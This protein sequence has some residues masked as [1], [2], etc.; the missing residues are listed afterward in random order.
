[1]SEDES[2][3]KER[4]RAAYRRGFDAGVDVARRD[5]AWRLWQAG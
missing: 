5:M 3:A 2:Q 1:M 4:E